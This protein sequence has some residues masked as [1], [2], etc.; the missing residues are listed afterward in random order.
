MHNVINANVTGVRHLTGNRYDLIYAAGLYD[1][2]NDRIAI[3][4]NKMLVPLL[5]EKGK[6]IVPNFLDSAPNRA[7]MELLQDWFLIYR[8]KQQILRLIDESV[9][10]NGD[11]VAYYED[12]YRSIG[13]AVY[14]NR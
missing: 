6:L 5:A 2:L 8:D 10:T 12:D 3:K 9:S 7:S 14:E 1:Y 13:W 4:L 11:N